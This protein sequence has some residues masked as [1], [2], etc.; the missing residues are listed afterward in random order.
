M[1]QRQYQFDFVGFALSDC[2]ISQDGPAAK[3][4]SAV[5]RTALEVA[6]QNL[7]GRDI[8]GFWLTSPQIQQLRSLPEHYPATESLLVSR[9]VEEYLKAQLQEWY[10]FLHSQNVLLSPAA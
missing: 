9:A 6:A 10:C 2:V 5:H 3:Y 4:L 8:G 1:E 7:F